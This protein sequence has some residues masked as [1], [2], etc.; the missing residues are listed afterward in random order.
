VSRGVTRFVLWG[1]AFAVVVIV[2]LVDALEL[3]V[4]VL[5]EY[6]LGSVV[7]VGSSALAA[8]VF[9]AIARWFRR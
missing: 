9:V 4:D 8:V 3:D 1:L 2:W 5:L 7:L 6:L